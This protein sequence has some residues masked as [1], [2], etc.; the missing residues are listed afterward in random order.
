MGQPDRPP[1]IAD[2][3]GRW[4]RA[5][6]PFFARIYA[7]LSPAWERRGYAVRRRELLAGLAGRVV[8]VGAGNGLNFRHYPLEVTAVLAIEPEPYLRSCAKV[9]A[10]RA[11]IPVE[12]VAGTAERIAAES[13]AFDSGVV[14]LVL[15]SVSDAGAALAELHR[16]IRPGGELR[17][18]EHVR[19]DSPSLR[20]IQ[21]LMDASVWPR[22]TGGCH[23]SRDSATAIQTAGFSMERL[24]SFRFPE[25]RIPFPTAPHI[26][27]VARRT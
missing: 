20:R 5:G 13:A 8:E 14:S 15:C 6:H 3:P 25:T 1:L 19:A 24:H 11:P 26:V 16:V 12:V 27:G 22:L 7:R 21:R 2:A 17:F 10:R 4:A 9:K 18:L 23:A